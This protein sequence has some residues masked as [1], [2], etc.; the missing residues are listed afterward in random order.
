M[1]FGCNASGVVGCRIIDSPRERLIAMITNSFV[2]CNGRFPMIISLITMYFVGTATGF[3][4]SV[5]SAF[6][7]TLVILLG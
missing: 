4:G 3:G 1:G 7:L 5:I 6:V 2:P